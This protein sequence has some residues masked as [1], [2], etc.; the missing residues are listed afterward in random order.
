V[1]DTKSFADPILFKKLE[2]VK[3]LKYF[4]KIRIAFVY[5]E[6]AVITSSIDHGNDAVFQNG[7]K[8]CT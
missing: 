5:F 6:F 3:A 4:K 8:K 2:C 1:S 7:H